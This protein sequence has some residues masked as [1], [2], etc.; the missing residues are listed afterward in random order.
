MPATLETLAAIPYSASMTPN[1]VLGEYQTITVTNA[2]AMTINAPT[3]FKV[4]QWLI[5][6]FFNNSGGA[7][8]AVTCNAAFL[9]GG[10]GT[11]GTGAV[12]NPATGKRRTIG[13]KYNGT[14][15]TEQFRSTADM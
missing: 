13:F 1:C 3:N 14:N 12:T 7:M 8:G 15:W 11:V 2:T 9:N 5:I 4:G 10:A 6:E